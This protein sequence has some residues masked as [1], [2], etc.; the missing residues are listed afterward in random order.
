MDFQGISSQVFIIPQKKEKITL[1]KNAHFNPKLNELNETITR[2]FFGE[3]EEVPEALVILEKLLISSEHRIENLISRRLEALAYHPKFEVRS[4]AYRIL[5]F[6][7]PRIDYDRYL[8]TFIH[9][10][11]PFLNK[12]VIEE[13]G[14]N[15]ID[16]INLNSFR[17][18]LEAYRSGLHWPVNDIYRHQFKRILELLVNFVYHN[19]G[20]Y[21]AVRAE[22]INW[23]LHTKDPQLSKFAKVLLNKCTAGLKKDLN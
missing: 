8:P 6:N 22:L 10:G 23:I 17:Q 20:S 2:A 12:K 19:P 15:N 13:I 7:Q 18:R 9:A 14:H 16:G 3:E 5:L 21:A 4:T 11:L 1:V